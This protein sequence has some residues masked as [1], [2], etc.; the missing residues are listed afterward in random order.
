MIYIISFLNYAIFSSFLIQ[1]FFSYICILNLLF[2]KGIVYKSTGSWYWV[3]GENDIFYSCRIKGKFRLEGIKNTNPI[4]V[5]DEVA[6]DLEK[7]TGN[8]IISTIFPRRNYIIRK[9]V[10]LSKRTHIIASNIDYA[11]LV[12]T[13]NNPQTSTAFIDR[14]LVTAEAYDI[15]SVLLFNKIDIYNEDERNEIKF[16]ADMYRKIG[17]QCIGI[18]AKT[19]KNIQQLKDLMQGSVSL[20]SGHSGVG[21]SSLINAISPSLSLKT[22]AIS[23][24]HQQG[25][26]TTTFAEMFDLD[27]GG[28]IIDTPGIKGFGLV[29]IEKEELT[30]YFPEF[31]ELKSACKFHNCLHIDEP[32]CAIKNALDEDK[33]W[34]SR[35]QSYLQIFNSEDETYRYD[36]HEKEED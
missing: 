33:L 19:G 28:S 7:K 2:M 11:F 26:H 15:R 30:D 3:K 25:Q 1:I 5:G 24:Q 20:V 31:F 34:W 23:Q 21:K 22:A 4:A 35:Y 29:D 16:L 18:S 27:F 13:L 17:Y 14:F 8:G 6:F 32:N 36:S 9:S 12:I 10:N